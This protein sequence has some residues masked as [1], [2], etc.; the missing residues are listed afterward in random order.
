MNK[1]DAKIMIDRSMVSHNRARLVSVNIA[2]TKSCCLTALDYATIV[3]SIF[4]QLCCSC[5]TAEGLQ[6][7]GSLRCPLPFMHARSSG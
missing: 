4:E 6:C 1:D 7:H 2:Y 3:D 5:E